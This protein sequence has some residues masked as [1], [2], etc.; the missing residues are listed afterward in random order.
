MIGTT[1]DVCGNMSATISMNTVRANKVVIT[2]VILSP[3][4]EGRKKDS[5]DRTGEKKKKKNRKETK[6]LA[7]SSDL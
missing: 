3:A 4:S 2:N 5:R 7:S 6:K 1:S